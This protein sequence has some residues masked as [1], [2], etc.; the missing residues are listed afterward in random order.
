VLPRFGLLS[1]L[2]SGGLRFSRINFDAAF[3]MSAVLDAYTRRRDIPD[4][5]AIA[6]DVDATTRVNITDN[7]SISDDVAGMDFGREFG[8]R[9]DCEFVTLQGNRSIHDTVNLQIF[10][11]RDLALDLNGCAKARDVARRIPV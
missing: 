11:A 7:F 9:A 1:Y 4:D 6:P 10:V 8:G 5:R 3:E 2:I